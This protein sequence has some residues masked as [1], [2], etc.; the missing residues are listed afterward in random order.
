MKPFSTIGSDQIRKA[1]T[2][3]STSK[4]ACAFSKE[5]RFGDPN[6]E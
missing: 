4:N 2:N 3:N 6:P 1:Q 5:K